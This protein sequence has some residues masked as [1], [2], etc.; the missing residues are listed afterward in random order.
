M[1]L[2]YRQD[3]QK[4]NNMSRK[5][6]LDK[7]LLIVKRSEK[8]HFGYGDR[9]TRFMDIEFAH[10]KFNLDLD[11][12]LNA[13]EFNFCHD[14]LG[15]QEGINRPAHKWENDLFVPRFALN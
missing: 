2:R 15:I 8:M 3:G 6:D 11:G 10:E 1:M 12:F 4:G 9:L 5:E 14:F 13:D 7:I